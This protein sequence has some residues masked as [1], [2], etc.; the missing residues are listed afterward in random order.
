MVKKK[1]ESALR[2]VAG[3]GSP[4]GYEKRSSSPWLVA[5]SGQG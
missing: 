2:S 5:V 1:R 3:V 4:F